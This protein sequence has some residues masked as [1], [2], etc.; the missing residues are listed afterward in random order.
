MAQMGF[1]IDAPLI[2]ANQ[3]A[4]YNLKTFLSIFLDS[5]PF[6]FH[7]GYRM[8][9]IKIDYLSPTE[10]HWLEHFRR[11]SCNHRLDRISKRLNMIHLYT[12]NQKR[13]RG[14]SLKSLRRDNDQIFWQYHTTFRQSHRFADWWRCSVGDNI[15]KV[16]KIKLCKLVKRFYCWLQ[17]FWRF[18]HH[19]QEVLVRFLLQSVRLHNDIIDFILVKNRF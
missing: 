17:E 8:F 3:R 13:D 7:H 5:F 2:I 14:L 19:H 6:V 9:L 10:H 15:S 4:G 11:S 1:Q 16:H 12:A 18:H